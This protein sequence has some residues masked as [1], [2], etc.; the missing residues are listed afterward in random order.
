M[1]EAVPSYKDTSRTTVTNWE[2]HGGVLAGFCYAEK[3]SMQV[4][5]V[6]WYRVRLA[7]LRRHAKR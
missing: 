1:Y 2:P 6:S 7:T 3:H 4:Y 5:L